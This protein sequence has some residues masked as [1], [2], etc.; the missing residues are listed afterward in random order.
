METKYSTIRL[1][2][3]HAVRTLGS[4]MM[5]DFHHLVVKTL[6]LRQI[7][8]ED[9]LSQIAPCHS[10]PTTQPLSKPHPKPTNRGY[11]NIPSKPPTSHNDYLELSQA[12]IVIQAYHHDDKMNESTPNERIFNP[13]QYFLG[14]NRA[15]ALEQV[16][17]SH[18]GLIS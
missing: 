14:P 4:R 15:Q 11:T 13:T 2:L 18:S 1:T 3:K 12:E 7:P 17:P 5:V 10:H 6:Q 16:S 8:R 9:H